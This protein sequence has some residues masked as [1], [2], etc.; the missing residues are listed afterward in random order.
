MLNLTSDEIMT[1]FATFDRNH[2]GTVDYDEYIRTLRGPLNN[3]RKRFVIQAFNKLD[4]DGSGK[5]TV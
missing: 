2:N 4:K 1:L 3:F 5:I